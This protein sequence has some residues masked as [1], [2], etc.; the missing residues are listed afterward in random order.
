MQTLRH[1]AEHQHVQ[2][3]GD[4]GVETDSHKQSKDPVDI[5]VRFFG[6]FIGGIFL[7][8]HLFH[9][10]PLLLEVPDDAHISVAAVH[11]DTCLDIVITLLG[12]VVHVLQPLLGHV[13]DAD[14]VFHLLRVVLQR[15]FDDG[16]EGQTDAAVD[17][18]LLA[19][20]IRRRCRQTIDQTVV[21]RHVAA[22]L[23]DELPE[24]QL[25]TLE[26]LVLFRSLMTGVGQV[27]QILL[28]LRIEHQG[29]L[30]RLFH[31]LRQT[32]KHRLA[33]LFTQF[34]L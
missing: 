33:L 3:D 30:V 32:L 9:V 20:S 5:P 25:L 18:C 2:T 34:S 27:E 17:L 1:K 13:V 11:E 29:V 16:G 26:L 7:R 28:F 22:G 19:E 4:E 24:R 23:V 10:G 14:I 15:S 8:H 6:V 31:G 12:I 21:A